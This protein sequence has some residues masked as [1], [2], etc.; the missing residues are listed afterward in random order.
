MKQRNKRILTPEEESKLYQNSQKESHRD[1]ML[2][3]TTLKLGLRNSEA[4][5]LQRKH[6]DLEDNTTHIIDSKNNKDRLVPIPDLLQDELAYYFKKKEIQD[7][8]DY[9]FPSKRRD[10]HLSTRAFEMKI[11]KYAVQSNLYPDNITLDNVAY[12]IPY[13]ERIVPHSLRHTYATRLL[14]Q[15]EPMAKVSRLLGHEKVNVT[16]EIYG[17][18]NVEDLRQTA[19]TIE[20]ISTG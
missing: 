16:V 1:Y 18:L 6:I 15:G 5:T 10:K 7:E 20:Q 13:R 12:R 19:Q 14:R 17:H 8:E 11:W 4:V 3:T 9:L 2:I